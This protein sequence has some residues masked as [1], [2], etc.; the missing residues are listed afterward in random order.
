MRAQSTS[1]ES[2]AFSSLIRV[3]CT[4]AVLKNGRMRKPTR[5]QTDHVPG[6]M[7]EAAIRTHYERGS[8]EAVERN[9]WAVLGIASSFAALLCA[10]ALVTLMLTQKVHVFQATKDSNGLINVSEVN[11]VF[12]A[13]EETQMAWASRW[14]SELTEIT[15]ALWQRNVRLVQ[16]RAVGVGLDQIKAYLQAIDNNPAQLVN[17]YPT[18]V[19]EYKRRSV[20]KVAPMTFLI[21][22]DLL[23]RP[24]A[25]VAPEIKSYAITV[26]LT[27]IGHKSRDDVFINPEGLAVLNFSISEEAS[28]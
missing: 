5:R 19:R 8:K 21:R 22:Y 11:S 3:I 20:N 25:G 23:S 18:Y 13:D 17:R 10:G 28:K 14:V 1:I 9:R 16:A 27:H 4:R 2:V 6:V 26:T 12:K 7:E 15:P 24:A